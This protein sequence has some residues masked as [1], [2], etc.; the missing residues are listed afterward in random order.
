MTVTIASAQ[1]TVSIDTLGAQ[2]TSVKTAAGTE[3]LWQADPA[4]WGR[5]APILFPIIGRLRDGRYTVHGREYAISQHGFAR[6]KAFTLLEQGES[7][8][9]FQL[10]EDAETLAKYPFSFQLQVRYDLE[11]A[12]LTKTHTVVN[13]SGETMYY[14]LGAHDGFRTTLFAG[15]RMEDYYI[16][17]P[18]QGE[19]HPYGM[20]EKG[21]FTL[22][23]LTYPLEGDRMPMPPRVFGL[24][25]VT[26]DD[27]AVREVTLANGRNP[28]RLTVAFEQFPYLGIWT[29]TSPEYTHYV[30]IEPWST[31]PE[32]E[33]TSSAL[34]EKPGIR[35][36]APGQSEAL[37]YTV[38]VD[39]IG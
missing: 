8:A 6:D 32:A 33:F 5:H 1:L 11:G 3:L 20:N 39:G 29:Q 37:A 28:I 22:P 38:T 7:W 18:G 31:L 26:L 4:I 2:L 17:F 15:E 25:T 9:V 23:K 21:H 14:E 12:S 16:Q 36:L 19:I 30:C 27:L 35:A 10:E 13:R 24:D 34:E